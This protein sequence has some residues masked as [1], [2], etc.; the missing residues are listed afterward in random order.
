MVKAA[1]LALHKFMVLELF[2]TQF[3]LFCFFSKHDSFNL[4][5]VTAVDPCR[6]FRP[7]NNFFDRLCLTPA[8]CSMPP[9]KKFFFFFAVGLISK[10]VI[11]P[12]GSVPSVVAVIS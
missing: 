8:I 4:F 6:L 7:R 1:D 5:V 10:C 2:K 11:A 3:F 12:H 9:F